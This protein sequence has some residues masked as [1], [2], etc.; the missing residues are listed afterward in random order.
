MSGV[1][2]LAL[3]AFDPRRDFPPLRELIAA[4]NASAGFDWFPSVAGLKVDWAPSPSFD[5]VTDACVAEEDGAM[6]ALARTSQRERAGEVVH[7]VQVWVRPDRQ[8]RGLG[9]RLLAWGE[10][11][12]RRLA[13]GASGRAAEL[14]HRF[15]GVTDQGNVAGVALL[16]TAGYAPFRFHS[17]MRRDLAEPIPD[18]PMPDGLEV[19]P[20]EAP[21]HRAVWL[22]DAEAFR[23]HWDASVVHE[24]DFV[25]FFA[26]PDIDTSLW[27]VAW[28]G[29]EIAGMVINGI[30]R[31]ENR[32]TGIDVGWL[33]DVSTRRPW[34]RRGLASAL[35]SRSLTLLRERGMTLAALGVDTENPTGALGIYERFGFRPVKTWAFYRKPF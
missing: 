5:P 24:E 27:Q 11:R 17:E 26:H 6:V 22:A 19:R 28:D 21:H 23:D 18:A 3:R 20:V 15:G 13:A 35:I 31:G 33:D 25:Q 32:R 30:N 9:S 2:A 10:D 12:A 16:T 29:D 1:A 7:A 34:R 4:A 14:P 8:R